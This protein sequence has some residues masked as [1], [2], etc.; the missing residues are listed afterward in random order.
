MTQDPKSAVRPDITPGS[1]EAEAGTGD[2]SF[3]DRWSR[4]KQRARRGEAQLPES[5]AGRTDQ[6]SPAAPTGDR[7]VAPDTDSEPPPL[8]SLDA[9]SDYSAFFSPKV[10]EELRRIALRKLF[11]SGKFNLRDGLDDY[12]DDYRTFEALGD[13]VTSDMRSQLEREAR[14][15]KDQTA[16]E[17][18]G[19]ESD[20]VSAVSG[21]GDEAREVEAQ[22]PTAAGQDA[23]DDGRTASEEPEERDV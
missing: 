9:E 23:E 14:N 3:L 20:R 7:S 16:R 18:A 1:E 22:A 2:E 19:D 6:D 15:A 10:S 8:E 11:G 21:Q 13:W 4:R 5:L 17:T 12:D